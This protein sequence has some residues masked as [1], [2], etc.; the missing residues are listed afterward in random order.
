MLLLLSRYLITG[1]SL[2]VTVA[3]H[4]AQGGGVTLNIFGRKLIQ[5]PQGIGVAGKCL[6]DMSFKDLS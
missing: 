6:V 2:Q 3:I 4:E 5:N 1:I